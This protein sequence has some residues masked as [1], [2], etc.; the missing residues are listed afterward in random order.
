M[1]IA[2][3]EFDAHLKTLVPPQVEKGHW[4]EALRAPP[5]A[6]LYTEGGANLRMEQ[7]PAQQVEKFI[8]YDGIMKAPETPQI[9]REGHQ[10]FYSHGQITGDIWIMKLGQ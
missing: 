4:V 2:Q 5:S 8:Y 10:L 6:M 3:A 9:S 1:Q 7:S